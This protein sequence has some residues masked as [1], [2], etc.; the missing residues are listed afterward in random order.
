MP[1]M[2][3]KKTICPYDC[4]TSC[5]LLAETDGQTVFH[6]DGDPDHPVTKGLICR[7]MRRYEKSIQAADRIMTPLKRQG[8]KGAGLFAPISWEEAIN[9]IRDN[10]L[11]IIAEDGPQAILPMYY[12]GVMSL[13]QRNCGDAFFNRMGACRLVKTLC[14]SAKQAG[15]E[16]VMGKTGCLDPR[17]LK[18]SDYYLIWGCNMK[19]TR[20]QAL[21]EIIKGRQAGKKAVLIET[22]SEDM[23]PH[24][25]ESLLIKPGT[26]GALALALMHILT[27]EGLADEPFLLKHSLGFAEFKDSLHHYTAAWAEGVT[28]IPAASIVNL[29][30]EYAAAQAPAIILGSGNSRYG[31][32]GMT[33]RLITILSAFTGA[34]QRP[35]GGLCGC[36]PGNG[37]Y[38]DIQRISRPDFRTNS[39]RRVNINQLASALTGSDGQPPVKSLFVYGG[40]PVG[41]VSNQTGIIK[42]LL[43]PDIFTVVHERFM[44]D[45][46]RYADVILPATF[47]VEQADCY[48]SYGYCTFGVAPKVIPPPGSCKSNWDTFRLLAKVM[49][50]QEDYFQRTEEE[51]LEELLAHPLP[52]LA[53]I[54]DN[55][56]A[57][58]RQGAVIDMPFADH[59]NWQT[60][61][62]KIQIINE[63]LAKPLPYYFESHGG[64]YP[65]R[66]VAVP[67]SHT[68]NS[69]FL[70]R[71]E[72]LRQRGLMTLALHPEDAADR[73]ISDCDSITAFNDLA[74]VGFIARVTDKVAKGA[75]AAVGI[76]TTAASPRGLLV[77][78]LHHERLS[79]I[80]EATTLNDNTIDVKIT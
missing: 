6:I 42:G 24:C 17:E 8:A 12:S 76:Y 51:M 31:N 3:I 65:L 72:L 41:S 73:G 5:G 48:N 46:A 70:E 19:A 16:A 78:A 62:G 1:K 29:A 32:G 52:A 74:E 25:D 80:G 28:G 75:A 2:E 18:D 60:K 44:T 58:L 11:R 54:D 15:Y 35:G 64:P 27:K 53:A 63:D 77:N 13:I 43:R 45:T 33:V 61:S 49:G 7:K 34:W 66:L 22:W 67:S 20:I 4:P 14:S 56:R 21:P 38:V 47:S 30:R 68:L 40:N 71:P 39:S 57:A 50:Y 10:W 36:N 26:D 79:D 59:L 23:A 55:D 69:I 37:Q 9:E